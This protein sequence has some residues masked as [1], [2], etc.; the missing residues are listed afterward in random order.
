MTWAFYD[1]FDRK[2][3]MEIRKIFLEFLRYT[4]LSVVGMVAVSFYIVADT[5][6]ISQVLGANGLAALNFAIPIVSIING[7]GLMIGM[8]AGTKYMIY[9]SQGKKDQAGHTLRKAIKLNLILGVLVILM[10]L[11][12]PEEVARLLGASGSVLDMTTTYI[13]YIFIFTPAFTLKH[14]FICIARNEGRPGLGMHSMVVASLANIVLDYIFM[15]PFGMGM[16]GAVIATCIAPIISI[17]IT[18]PFIWHRKDIFDTGLEK[19][20]QQITAGILSAGFPSMIAEV[21]T[22]VVIIVFNLLIFSLSGNVGVAAYGVIANISLIVIAIYTGIAQGV[23]PLFSKNYGLG[24]PKELALIVKFASLSVLIISTII[25]I[26][27]YLGAGWVTAIFNSE[28]NLTLQ[29]IAERGIRIYF[30]G[31][32]FAGLNILASVYLTSIDIAKPAHFISLLR[33]I[34]VIIPMAVLMSSLW[35]MLGV[36]ASFPL[37]EILVFLIATGLLLKISKKKRL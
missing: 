1:G 34:I 23:Q 7:I 11:F 21:S 14:V 29:R 4:T 33:G 30:I 2:E 25:Y 20:T 32:G 26:S 5:F 17:A 12:I 3:D 10:G 27:T 13:K 36:W 28:N 22:A 35:G 6:F 18:L 31:G 9:K 16:F 37:T 19:P 8:G 15:Y 24:R